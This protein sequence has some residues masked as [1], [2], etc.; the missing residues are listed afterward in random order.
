MFMN[1]ILIIS[2]NTGSHWAQVLR[3]GIHFFVRNIYFNLLI[4]SIVWNEA[5][6][7]KHNQIEYTHS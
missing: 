3:K 1:F 5:N 4:E 7:S 2:A 6:K